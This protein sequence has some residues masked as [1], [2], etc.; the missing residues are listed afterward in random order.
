[1][2]HKVHIPEYKVGEKPDYR[3]VGRKI[4]E[5]IKLHFLGKRVGL[6]YLS[7]QD[8]PGHTLDTLTQI[9]IQTGTDRY[10]PK[11]KMSVAHDFYDEKGVELFV[12]PVTVNAELRVS[13]NTISDFWDGALEDRGYSLRIDLVVIYD[14]EQLEKID[15]RYE[16]GNVGEG[17][18]KFRF[19]A[20]KADAILGIIQIL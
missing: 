6:R 19:P 12:M 11:R 7:L 14:L 16:D 20:R 15:I 3:A 13:E 5:E 4:D 2:I 9:I 10:D 1:M 8:H 18:Y 17:D